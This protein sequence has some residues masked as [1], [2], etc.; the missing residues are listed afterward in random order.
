MAF[1]DFL[2]KKKEIKLICFDLDNTL[3]R[4]RVAET[5]T[6]AHLA[7][8]IF[9]DIK[10]LSK[11]VNIQPIDILRKFTEIKHSH[12][13]HEIDPKKFSRDLWFKE[14]FETLQ[15]NDKTKI[16]LIKNS[17]K[18]EKYYWNYLTP[19]LS[20]FP[21]SANLLEGL[22]QTKKYKLALLTDSDGKKEFKLQRIK[23]L[24]I[25]KYFDYVITTDVTGENKPSMKNFE[26]LLKISCL[27]GKN[28]MMVG[29]HP[30]V[31]LI[32]AKKLAFTTVW[33]KESL[34]T[35]VHYNY[36]DFEIH[37]IIE[38]LDVLKKLE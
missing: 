21:N 17:E 24:E 11:K 25:E 14:T 36:V 18:Y 28:C 38:V 37:D 13:H 34:N 23:F 3:E 26:Y 9:S 1:F 31:D 22:K 12:M 27:E 16:N 4:Y 32:N 30:D 8:K 29:D 6:E 15:I 10:K 20:L 33:T 2:K 35:D 19:R 5:E 7:E